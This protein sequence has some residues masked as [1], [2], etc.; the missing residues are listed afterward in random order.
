MISDAGIVLIGMLASLIGA[1]ITFI[2][3][4][5]AIH[6]RDEYIASKREVS[7]TAAFSKEKGNP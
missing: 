5:L 3:V 2:T 4:L 1:T 7:V 6:A